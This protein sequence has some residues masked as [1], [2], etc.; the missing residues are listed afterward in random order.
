MD[1]GFGRILT[2]SLPVDF[3]PV[4]QYGGNPLR[5]LALALRPRSAAGGAPELAPLEG[6]AKL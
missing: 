5:G 4:L 1:T 2:L 3:P 6:M